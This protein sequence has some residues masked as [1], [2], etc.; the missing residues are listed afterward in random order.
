MTLRAAVPQLLGGAL[1]AKSTA[2]LPALAMLNTDVQL[3][4]GASDAQGGIPAAAG[5]GAAHGAG[6]G[7]VRPHRRRLYVPVRGWVACAVCR[8]PYSSCTLKSIAWNFIAWTGRGQQGTAAGSAFARE[9]VC[10]SSCRACQSCEQ[11]NAAGQAALTR[12]AV[13]RHTGRATVR[14]PE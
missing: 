10:A 11:C 3:T 7:P 12:P 2:L 13:R 8:M 14:Q 6:D 5:R 1:L 9:G 4:G